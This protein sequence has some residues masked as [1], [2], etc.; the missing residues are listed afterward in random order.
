MRPHAGDRV[1][2]NC[3][4]WGTVTEVE[5]VWIWVRL[6]NGALTTAKWTEVSA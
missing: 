2:L 5:P 6:D 3:R 4:G 1:F